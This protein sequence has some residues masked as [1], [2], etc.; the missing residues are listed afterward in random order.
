MV[1][2]LGWPDLNAPARTGKAPQQ[3]R[4]AEIVEYVESVVLDSGVGWEVKK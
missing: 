1:S 3:P 2:H 4:D